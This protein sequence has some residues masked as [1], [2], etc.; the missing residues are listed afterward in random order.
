MANQYTDNPTLKLQR[1]LFS[2]NTTSKK[3]VV[4]APGANRKI[5]VMG[6]LMSAGNTGVGAEF[7]AGTTGATLSPVLT[8]GDSGNIGEPVS[9]F[10]KMDDLPE[11]CNLCLQLDAEETVGGIVHYTVVHTKTTY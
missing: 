5:R 1:A 6:F 4:A 10:P 2:S 11:N 3:E 7:Y 8:M 9:E